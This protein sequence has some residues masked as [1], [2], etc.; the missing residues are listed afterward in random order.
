MY[1]IKC[2]EKSTTSRA[3]QRCAAA[4][5]TTFITA[6]TLDLPTLKPKCLGNKSPPAHIPS[7]SLL[8]ISC[9]NI[10]L[11]VSI[12]LSG[13]PADGWAGYLFPLLISTRIATVERAAKCTPSG[14]PRMERAV[15]LGQSLAES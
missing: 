8:L 1:D 6:T 7:A 9:S 10:F 14:K 5:S 12:R 4:R 2:Y 11:A 3:R 13:Q 15:A